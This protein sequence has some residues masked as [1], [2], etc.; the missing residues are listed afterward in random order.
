VR[1][2]LVGAAVALV[3]ML[4]QSIVLGTFGTGMRF[5]TVVDELGTHV[6]NPNQIG[7]HFAFA[8]LL[9]AV[10]ST[11]GGMRLGT[12]LVLALVF[13][14][15]TMLTGSR[16]PFVALLVSLLIAVAPRR[17]MLSAVAAL[18]V[19]G[20]GVTEFL[21]ISVVGTLVDRL[22]ADSV[23]NLG[24]R[25]EIWSEGLVLAIE[26]PVRVFLG[27]GTG[28]AER[29][30]GSVLSDRAHLGLDGIPR[31]NPHNTYLAVFLDLGL[32]GFCLFG[33]SVFCGVGTC[34][35]M[36]RL[37][38]ARQRV[39]MVLFALISCW[40]LILYRE[41]YWVALA[42]LLMCWTMRPRGKGADEERADF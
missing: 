14:A 5:G 9:C 35:A 24:D 41:V 27:L 2:F 11:I 12:G 42:S 22:S 17:G 34:L 31:L 3:F 7:S 19:V 26:T 23:Y 8:A 16:G 1:A 29:G 28:G 39:P 37:E 32:V 10:G 15:G 33:Y 21:G 18:T 13:M 4:A 40:T 30:L 6:T 20:I 25:T 36:D 38:Q